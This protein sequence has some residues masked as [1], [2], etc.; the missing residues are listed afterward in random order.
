M[1]SYESSYIERP[2]D[3]ETGTVY[4]PE[5]GTYVVPDRG[6]LSVSQTLEFDPSLV[7][8]ELAIGEPPLPGT[9]ERKVPW[10]LLAA[11]AASVFY[12]A[13]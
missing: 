9:N 3:P 6:A 8:T 4:V 7:D 10:V 5:T 12:F 11:A 1:T 2:Y 13:S